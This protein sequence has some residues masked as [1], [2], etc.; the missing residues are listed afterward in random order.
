MHSVLQVSY[1]LPIPNY[2]YAYASHVRD[3][4]ELLAVAG[5]FI[6]PALGSW[7]IDILDDALSFPTTA[8]KCHS[9]HCGHTDSML[10]SVEYHLKRSINPTALLFVPWHQLAQMTAPPSRT[11]HAIPY[12]IDYLTVA[13]IWQPNL[14]LSR[15]PIVI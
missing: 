15:D 2:A 5:M 11:R 10:P 4:V 14:P 7:L 1:L 9:Q 13:V 3:F 6:Q 12:M 8:R